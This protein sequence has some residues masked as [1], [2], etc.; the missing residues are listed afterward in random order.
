MPD[1]AL[2]ALNL[3]LPVPDPASSVPVLF[4]CADSDKAEPDLG[5]TGKVGD[6]LVKSLSTLLAILA[7]A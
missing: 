6:L 3:T 4:N 5:S 1:P 2:S 7:N